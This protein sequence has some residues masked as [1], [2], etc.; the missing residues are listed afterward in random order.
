MIWDDSAAET[1]EESEVVFDSAQTPAAEKSFMDTPSAIG[2]EDE[3]TIGKRHEEEDS[4]VLV[5][6][7]SQNSDFEMSQIS[8]I[9]NVMSFWIMF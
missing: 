2:T 5:L 9:L 7:Y 4:S 3:M 1:S 8:I 6:D